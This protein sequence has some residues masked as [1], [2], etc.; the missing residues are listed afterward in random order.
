MGGLKGKTEGILNRVSTQGNDV[1]NML[2]TLSFL[3]ES[4]QLTEVQL[5]VSYK[6][7]KNINIKVHLNNISEKFLSIEVREQEY[8]GKL[9]DESGNNDKKLSSLILLMTHLDFVPTLSSVCKTAGVVDVKKDL[10]ESII[11]DVSLRINHLKESIK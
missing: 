7:H 5:S 4:D 6:E 2:T 3:L 10:T 11:D 1:I 9:R 8:L